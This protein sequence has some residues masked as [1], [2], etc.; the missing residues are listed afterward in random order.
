MAQVAIAVAVVA[1]GLYAA[2]R[3]INVPGQK[4]NDLAVQTAKEGEPIPVV[5]GL[6]RPIGG[7]LIAVQEP[8]RI[9]RRKQK[10]GGKGGGGSSTTV[11]VPRRTYAVGVCE[12]PI[13][14]Y[15]RIWRNN[16]LVY[17]GRPG[18]EWGARNNGT[19][20]QRFTL[21]LGAWN[22]MPDPNLESIFGVGNVPAHR[23]IAYMV[24]RDEDLQDTGGAVPQWIFEVERAEGYFVT[25][26]PYAVEN[27]DEMSIS[28]IPVRTRF[29]TSPA[30]HLDISGD[31]VSANLRPLVHRE[32]YPD[33]DE[34]DISGDLVSANLRTVLR[35][36]T[37]ETE[38]MDISGALVSADLVQAPVA[39]SLLMHFDGDN[40]STVFI[41][42]AGNTVTR[43][44][45]AQIDTEFYVFGG[46][47]LLLGSSGDTL[48]V[49]YAVSL[50]IGTADVTLEMRIR[51]ASGGANQVLIDFR[52]TSASF[53][54]GWVMYVSS[55]NKLAIYNGVTNTNFVSELTVPV[56]EFCAV[57]ADREGAQWRLYVNGVA[58]GIF[59]SSA[60][61]ATHSTG[62]KIGAQHDGANQFLGHIDE[63]RLTKGLARYR[64]SYTPASEPF[65]YP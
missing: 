6:A 59:S 33:G 13:T 52:G 37:I 60:N 21:Y 18:S 45:G 23:G 7:N 9:E 10:S 2:T 5:W 62:I 1:V 16:K 11:E 47:S 43:T 29:L 65:P 4:L 14:G 46:S 31:L 50:D 42:E 39:P 27:I 32:D 25:S 44:G 26:R 3:T 51:R 63:L 35:R 41:D 12:G 64:G 19:F 48:R 17:D 61:W 58:S 8:P 34:L 28:G 15:R 36:Y 20:L 49:P 24:A 38:T 56:G 22:A 30:D 57:A 40:G 55:D 53:S 54:S